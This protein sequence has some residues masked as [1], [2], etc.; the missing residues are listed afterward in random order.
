MRTITVVSNDAPKKVFTTEATT[1]GELL[2]AFTAND[3]N[4]SGKAIFEGLTKL[5]F[6]NANSDVVLPSQVRYRDTVTDDLVFMLTADKKKISSGIDRNSLYVEVRTLNLA[7]AIKMAFGRNFT[8]VSSDDLA[9]FIAQKKGAMAEANYCSEI[10]TTDEEC[11]LKE[12]V[13]NVVLSTLSYYMT[14]G[15]VDSNDVIGLLVQHGALVCAGAPEP[16]KEKKAIV[17]SPY[18]D[19][20]VAAM[21]H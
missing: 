19:E 2:N 12:K 14:E 4:Y 15:I 1:V 9:A 6:T 20:E 17:A 7:D 8:Q 3:I 18:S 11:P 21:F 5:E 10:D 13:T 16:I